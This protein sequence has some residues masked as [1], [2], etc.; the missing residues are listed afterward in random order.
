MSK[1][2]LEN[3]L[4]SVL[5]VK[6]NNSHTKERVNCQFNRSILGRDSLSLNKITIETKRSQEN[7]TKKEV[8]FCNS[9][10]EACQILLKLSIDQVSSPISKNKV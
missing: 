2:I 1:D 10:K 9:S 8:I 7:T 3:S 4:A 5:S 6:I